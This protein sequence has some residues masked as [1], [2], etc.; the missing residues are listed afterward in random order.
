MGYFFDHDQIREVIL[1]EMSPLRKR[2]LH[3][4]AVNALIKVFGHKPELE[5]I[6]AYHFEEAGEP[7]KGI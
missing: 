3:L 1:Q 5:S 6:Y 4:A 2:H 7:A